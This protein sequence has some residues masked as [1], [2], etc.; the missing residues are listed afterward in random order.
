MAKTSVAV[1]NSRLHPLSQA[2]KVSSVTV[3]STRQM[4]IHAC[5]VSDDVMLQDVRFYMHSDLFHH[6]SP[7][8]RELGSPCTDGKCLGNYAHPPLLL[9]L[10]RNSSWKSLSVLYSP[11]INLK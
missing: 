10:P 3:T 6:N 8:L 7:C 9:A 2:A 1:E 4:H 11:S 5:T